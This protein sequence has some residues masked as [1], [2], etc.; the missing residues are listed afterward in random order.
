MHSASAAPRNRRST[1]D[2]EATAGKEGGTICWVTPSS[3][4]AAT[5]TTRWPSPTEG[6]RPPQVPARMMRR[7]PARHSSSKQTAAPGAPTPCEET[8]TGAPRYSPAK[9]AYSRNRPS[10]RA[11]SNRPATIS[12]RAGSP[13]TNTRSG[14]NP[15]STR[16]TGVRA[17]YISPSTTAI[18]SSVNSYR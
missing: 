2:A 13:T 5:A 7:A 18:S 3:R 8:A 10:N 6:C 11:P 14:T 16:K 4:T 9:V 12:A 15:T 1:T 17:T